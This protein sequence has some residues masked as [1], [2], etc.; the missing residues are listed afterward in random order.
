MPAVQY[1]AKRPRID[2]VATDI[3]EQCMLLT[4]ASHPQALGLIFSSAAC[5]AFDCT[6]ATVEVRVR[7][8]PL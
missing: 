4:E 7:Q 2:M 1:V 5:T 3:Q 6:A 8:N